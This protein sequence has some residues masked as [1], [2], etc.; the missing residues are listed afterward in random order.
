[1]HETGRWLAGL[2]LC[3]LIAICGTALAAEEPDYTDVNAYI[4]Q[5]EMALQRNDYLEAVQE[6]RKAAELSSSV[7][8]AQNR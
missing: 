3:A 2:S 5:A 1:M 7:E 8:I 4:L 6:Y